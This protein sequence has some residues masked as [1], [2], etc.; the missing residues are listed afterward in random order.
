M[1]KKTQYI[2]AVYLVHEGKV[3]LVHHRKFDMWL[4]VGGHIENGETTE[5]ALLREVKEECGI[6]A[7]IISGMH[8]VRQAK[9]REIPAP[10]YAEVYKVDSS[11]RHL[12]F[13]YFGKTKTQRIKFS[14]REHK[15][16]GW[17]S[18]EDLGNIR[19][20]LL[21]TIRHHALEALKTA[22]KK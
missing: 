22:R 2:V 5:E 17:F 11:L 14:E 15:N 6:R 21:P 18:K 3:L 4:P 12:Y 7:D 16:Y 8:E 10:R 20:K 9:T 19:P 1:K 13:I